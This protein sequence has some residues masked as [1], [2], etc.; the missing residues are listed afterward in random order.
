MTKDDG[1]STSAVRKGNELDVSSLESYLAAH[2]PGFVSPLEIKQFNAGQSNPTYL[3]VDGTKKRY[4]LRKKPPGNLLSRTAHAVEREY[5][6]IKALGEH[7]DVPVPK[8][9]ALCEDNAVIGTPFYVM[10]FLE[11]RIFTD[12]R[13]LSL[14]PEDRKKCWYSALETLAK[15]HTVDF[16]AVGLEDYGRHHGFYDRQIKSL[17]KVSGAQALVTDK[18][19]KAVGELPR[20]QE[21][22]AWFGR[23]QV[24]DEA[25]LVHGDYKIDNLI[26]HPTEPR[27]IGILDWELSTIGH[28]LS[29]LANLL[30]P[31][32][33]PGIPGVLVGFKGATE[34]L[35]IPG[36][37]ELMQVY[38]AKARRPYPIENWLFVICFSFFRLAVILQGI[39]ARLASGQATS[40]I[41]QF[42]AS[43][44]EPVTLQALEI[45]DQGDVANSKL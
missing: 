14:E 32:Y 44:F 31:F 3:L 42:Y 12:I 6:I 4:V 43:Q 20:L 37:E 33:F 7:T 2:V 17:S 22:L 21:L 16:K 45:V 11:G 24:K 18:D 9:Y 30:N 19:G 40:K 1:Q 27:V 38:C 10:E 34:P 23:N 13:F 29:D 5:R 28:P 39:A 36:L 26:F 41:A 15:F 25:T 35:P 8:V